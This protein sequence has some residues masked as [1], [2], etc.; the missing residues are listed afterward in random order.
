MQNERN[1]PKVEGWRINIIFILIAAVFSYYVLRLFSLQILQGNVFLE[2][3]EEN[4]RTN[5]SVQT[6]R[7]IIYDRNGVV[8]ARNKASYNV[9]IVPANLPG[10]PTEEPI[11]GAIEE[12]YRELSAVINIPVRNGVLNDKSLPG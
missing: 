7:G 10:D 12:I 6:E 2:Q 5:I 8:L 4:R 9:T 1:T 3:A 11:P